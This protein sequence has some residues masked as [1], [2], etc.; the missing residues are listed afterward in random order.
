M[1]KHKFPI[2]CFKN[3]MTWSKKIIA[4]QFLL[5]H[6]IFLRRRSECRA[7][8]FMQRNT[9]SLLSNEWRRVKNN[10]E[11]P[12]MMQNMFRLSSNAREISYA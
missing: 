4:L 8:F 5:F 2:W 7:I 12:H 1:E 6:A 3:H 11:Y 9:R 10:T